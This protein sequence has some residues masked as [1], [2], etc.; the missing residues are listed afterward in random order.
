MWCSNLYSL[1]ETTTHQRSVGVR[2]RDSADS[3]K[4]FYD[5]VTEEDAPGYHSVISK[6]MSFFT[7]R[8]K[9]QNKEYIA[10]SEFTVCQAHLRLSIGAERLTP[11]L[12]LILIL[13]LI[14]LRWYWMDFSET[15]I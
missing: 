13:I 1:I 11:L 10:Y 15:W 4:I 6:P 5:P 14:L 9:M 2:A 8:N 7:M 3:G 12:M